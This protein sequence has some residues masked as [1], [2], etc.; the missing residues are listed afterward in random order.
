MGELCNKL[1]PKAVTEMLNRFYHKIETIGDA[2]FAVGG[3][4]V[5][6]DH[7]H[8]A[9]IIAFGEEA[10]QAAKETSIALEGSDNAN[11]INIRIGVHSGACVGAVVGSLN[12]KVSLYG[13]TVNVVSRI[14][15]TGKPDSIHVSSDAAE[16]LRRQNPGMGENLHFRGSTK[17]KGKG[18]MQTYWYG[19]Q[20][21]SPWERSP[22]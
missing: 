14:E 15:T 2:Y 11:N 22:E 7:D 16:L 4:L 21:Q 19:T 1:G 6:N 12:P 20:P 8:C 5:E 3:M 10:F 17:L 13:D 18:Y 9:R